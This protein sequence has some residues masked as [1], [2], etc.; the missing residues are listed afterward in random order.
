M[1]KAFLALLLSPILCVVCRAI[2][3]PAGATG[4]EIILPD[5]FK[6]NAQLALTPAEHG[7]GLMFVKE[8]PRNQGMLFVFGEDGVKYFWMKDTF[9]DLDMVFLSREMITGRVF[10]R[11]PRSFAGQL[12][13]EVATA[14]APARFVLELA[15]GTARAHGIKPG[16]K[17]KIS[18][19]K[20]K[21]ADAVHSS[22]IPVSLKN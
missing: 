12:E 17:L 18:F 20:V 16:S 22:S 9:I 10:H 5:G 4:A 1:K 7:K 21:Q 6:V 11:V 19:S 2:S 14:S 8:L 3:V 15:G 13:A